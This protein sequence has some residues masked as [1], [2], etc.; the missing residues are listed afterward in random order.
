MTT[1]SRKTEPDLFGG[2]EWPE[3]NSSEFEC[4][5]PPGSPVLSS[6]YESVIFEDLDL[7]E[8]RYVC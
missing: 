5:S 4:N 6:D 2:P 8:A 3:D 7:Y 1:R